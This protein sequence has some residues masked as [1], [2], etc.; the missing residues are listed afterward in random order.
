MKFLSGTEQDARLDRL[1][2]A[3]EDLVDT[4]P[5]Q[6]SM[7]PHFLPFNRRHREAMARLAAEAPAREAMLLAI[8]EAQRVEAERRAKLRQDAIRELQQA[9]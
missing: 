1:E 2:A 5:Y 7:R 8:K 3:M 6:A 9:P 4:L